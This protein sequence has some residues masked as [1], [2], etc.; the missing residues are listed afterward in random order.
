MMKIQLYSDIH[1]EFSPN[2][3]FRIPDH[4]SDLIVLCGDIGPG[5]SGLAWAGREMN[6]LGKQVLYVPGNHEFYNREY[7]SHLNR[8]KSKAEDLGVVLLSDSVYEHNGYRFIGSTLWTSFLDDNGVIDEEAIWQAEDRMPDFS[9]IRF[10]RGLFAPGDAQAIHLASMAFIER[11]LLVSEK[12][13]TVLVTH[14]G[15]SHLCVNPKFPFRPLS[16]CFTSNAERLLGRSSLWLYGHTHASLD[17]NL[18]GTRVISNQM[19]YPGESGCGFNPDLVID[20]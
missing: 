1:V 11:E 3:R 14:H 10:G 18:K 17:F 4:D 12:E 8:M 19:G 6:R 20:I 7:I 5:L 15:P 16:R 13:K 9:E 2:Y